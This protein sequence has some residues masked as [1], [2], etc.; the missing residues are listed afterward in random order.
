MRGSSVWILLSTHVASYFPLPRDGIT[1]P[2]VLAQVFSAMSSSGNR[3]EGLHC[4]GTWD[5]SQ[6][7]GGERWIESTSSRTPGPTLLHAGYSL[8]ETVSE[9]ESW[10]AAVGQAVEGGERPDR[11]QVA[12]TAVGR[13]HSREVSV[14]KHVEWGDCRGCGK[15]PIEGL[16]KRYHFITRW[17][18]L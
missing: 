11:R 5:S 17:N 2:Q 12:V 1:T 9:L 6:H 3:P 8:G 10:A 18:V 4:P 7:R 13:Q 15:G 14:S 16:Q